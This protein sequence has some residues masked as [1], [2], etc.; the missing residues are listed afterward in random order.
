MSSYPFAYPY[1]VA[2]R[3]R[4]KQAGANESIYAL[5]PQPQTAPARPAMYGSKYPADTPPS[6]STFGASAASQLLTTNLAGN[7]LHHSSTHRHKQANATFG[8][9]TEHTADPTHFQRKDTNPS[10]PAPNRFRYSD[11]NRKERVNTVVPP[12]SLQ[13]CHT[14]RAQ[15]IPHNF[16]AQNALNVINADARRPS[17]DPQPYTKKKGYGEVPAYLSRV[18][19]SIENEKAYVRAVLE[20]QQQEQ[21]QQQQ[22][23]GYGSGGSGGAV[24]NGGVGMRVLSSEAQAQLLTGLKQKWEHVNRLYQQMTHLVTLDTVGKIR[25]K[26]EF[27]HELEQLEKSIERMSKPQVFVHDTSHAANY[28]LY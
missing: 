3:R 15:Q 20:Q 8:P 13:Q 16:I 11:R 7:Y 27:E 18:K 24:M 6:S 26:E 21:Q 5:I 14:L 17:S 2:A 28:P 4:A 9:P 10:L 12:A 23:Y 19:H 1:H 25:R 22:Q